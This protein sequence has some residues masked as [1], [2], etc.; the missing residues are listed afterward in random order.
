[1]VDGLGVHCDDE[2]SQSQ[3]HQQHLSAESF[4][5]EPRDEVVLLIH[6][7]TLYRCSDKYNTT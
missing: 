4:P 5:G 1:M 6:F 7:S 3:Q 2:S